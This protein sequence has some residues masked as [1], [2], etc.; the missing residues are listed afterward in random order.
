M[1]KKTI[2]CEWEH[3]FLL[4]ETPRAL[5]VKA[6]TDMA[7]KEWQKKCSDGLH[8][9]FWSANLPDSSEDFVVEDDEEDDRE[10]AGEDQAGPVDIVSAQSRLQKSQKSPHRDEYLHSPIS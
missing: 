1:D 4:Q 3:D 5:D 9:I 10:G 2:L 8:D 6:S 7:E